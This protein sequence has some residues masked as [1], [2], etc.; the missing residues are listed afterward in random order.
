MTEKHIKNHELENRAHEANNEIESPLL[1]HK[2]GKNETNSEHLK[3]ELIEKSRLEAEKI[4]HESKIDIQDKIKQSTL[5]TETVSHKT[6]PTNSYLKG[7][8]LSNELRHIQRKLNPLDKLGSQFI[9][10][11]GISKVSEISANTIYRPSGL[12]GGGIIA[13]IGTLAYYFYAKHIGLTYNYLIALFL[14]VT[15]FFIGLILEFFFKLLES[16]K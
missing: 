2:Q 10:Q 11:K 5:E 6:I 1:N 4:H 13:F 14:F 7:V 9:H 12:L 15:G 16:R 8:T 3:K